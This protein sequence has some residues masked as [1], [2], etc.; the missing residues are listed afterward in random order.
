VARSRV[1]ADFYSSLTCLLRIAC[2][3]LFA[4]VPKNDDG[5]DDDDL[6]CLL[7]GVSVL[8]RT[9]VSKKETTI[10]GM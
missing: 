1:G 8:S 3:S 9:N 10:Q 5:D 4:I 6:L 2:I 7:I